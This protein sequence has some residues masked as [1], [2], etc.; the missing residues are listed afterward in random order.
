[1]KTI[2]LSEQRWEL[3]GFWPWVPLQGR[4][5]ETAAELMGVT[6]WLPAT[7]PGGVHFDLYRAGLIPNPLVDAQSLH[8][9]WVENRWWLY[10][11]TLVR[12]EDT[13]D[14]VE[15]FF[16]GVDYEVNVFA[17][18]RLL[19]EH[20]GMFH[21]AR[22]DLTALFAEH[23]R[24][25]LKVLF[26][27]VP[28]EMSQIGRT[29]LTST[30]KSRFGYKWDFATRLVNIGVWDD[31]EL[32]VHRTATIGE[33]S[34]AT[35]I[36]EGAG[37]LRIAVGLEH[38]IENAGPLELAVTLAQPG[39]GI[40]LSERYMLAAGVTVHA[41]KVLVASPQLWSPNGHG[42]QPL[43]TLELTLLAGGTVVDRRTRRIGFRKLRY[44]RNSGGPADALPYTIVVNGKRIYVQGVNLTPLDHLYGNV[45]RGHY[46]WMVRCMQ[47]ANVN[48]V[49]VWGGGVIEKEIFYDLCDEAGIMVWQEFIQ[50][51]SGVDN[52]PS[53]RP[54]FL[55][56]LEK[57][58]HS[59]IKERRNHTC[60]TVWSGG[61][62]LMDANNVPS[63]LA[64]PN[65]ARLHELVRTLD[66][67]RLFLP[68][69]ASGPVEHMTTEKGVMHDVHGHWKYL[70]PVRH[71]E[72]YGGSDSL[73][74]SEFGVDGC[75]GVQSLRKFLSAPHQVPTDVKRS[76]VWR[77]RAEWWDTA[78][79]DRDFF[80]PVEELGLF[81][82]CSQWIQA[83][84][85]RYVLEANRRRQPRN[86]GSIIWQLNEPWPNIACTNLVDYY[87]AKKMAYYWTRK[88]FSAVHVSL[89]Y[90]SLVCPAGQEF[91]AT[92]HVHNSDV[93]TELALKIEVLTG[94]GWVLL[95]RS[96]R[97]AVEAN[98]SINAARLAFLVSD[99]MRGVFFVR[100]TWN[101]LEVAGTNLYVFSTEARLPYA[102]AL[103]LSQSAL[104]V[105]PLADWVTSEDGS[106][107][108]RFRLENTGTHVALFVRAEEATNAWWLH[109]DA[110]YESLF[111]REAREVEV[112]CIPKSAGGFLAEDQPPLT[113]APEISF[114]AWRGQSVPPSPAPELS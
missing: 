10:R 83:E 29:S 45:T 98:C 13:G 91:E 3:K 40:V 86:S 63:T 23:E 48:L 89:D 99:K 50:S 85:L 17:N 65:L 88:A 59:A 78:E 52:I 22:F 12:P 43:Y 47:Q 90:R 72:T 97:H 82:D 95:E 114:R 42:Q 26:R 54:E 100:L 107:R 60:L 11:T 61:N 34:L 93:A 69:S 51:S 94:E 87:G 38:L 74:H 68:T 41:G 81:T 66:P 105:R 27:G 103:G 37:V 30:Q 73:F 53:Q 39:G 7:V 20:R 80:G 5:M 55:E 18:D 102:S 64:D 110:G 76:L 109:E 77:H 92:I 67:E 2:S 104:V 32:R 71:Y 56:L 21:P 14:C 28:P 9:E 96:A 8:C 36:D 101:E 57:T 33:I 46:A 15:L 44:E 1:M 62:E 106:L 79:R 35:D 31:V 16:R 108:R 25:E 111:P 75:S 113:A 6:D 58:A 70:G 19:G 49:R 4:S 112:R 24:V 84:G